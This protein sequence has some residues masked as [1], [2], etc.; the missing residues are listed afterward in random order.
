M[1]KRQENEQ[2]A[3]AVEFA[4]VLVPFLLLVFG[5]INF[6]VVFAQN[7]A[8]NN[9]A[10]QAARSGAVDDGGV[11]CADIDTNARED[12]KSLALTDANI[13]D[14]TVVIDPGCSSGMPC[15]GSSPGDSVNVTLTYSSDF[16]VPWPIPG[17]PQ[18]IEL[19]GEGEFRCE[20]S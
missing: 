9:A 20:F 17:L 3:A 18:S 12:S 13:D 2:G 7:L 11:T 5:M 10:R 14:I 16:L 19:E 8:L 6:G 1:R 4:L 15:E